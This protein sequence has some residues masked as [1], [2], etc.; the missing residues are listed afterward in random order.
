MASKTG[1]RR[2]VLGGDQLDVVLLALELFL[3]EL[4]DDRVGLCQGYFGVT[5]HTDSLP[6]S[7]T[8]VSLA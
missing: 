1:H 2:E 4:A 3:Y 6:N 7:S 5:L 8:L